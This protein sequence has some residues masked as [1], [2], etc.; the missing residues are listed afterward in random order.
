MNKEYNRK[1][2]THMKDGKK[3]TTTTVRQ[4][5]IETKDKEEIMKK[6]QEE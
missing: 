2:D 4:R 1:M 6:S 3:T 5:V